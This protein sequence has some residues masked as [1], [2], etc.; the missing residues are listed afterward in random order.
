MKRTLFL[1][2][3]LLLAG[4]CPVLQNEDTPV[5]AT[6]VTSGPNRYW[7]YVPSY[8][9]TDR[10]WPLVVTLHGTH[11][12]DSDSD[13]IRSWKLLAEEKG[14]IVVAPHMRSVQGI[15]PVMRHLWYADLAKDEK[16]ILAVLD[17]VAAKYNV[18]R[19]HVILTGF[20]AGGYPLYYTGL[21]N[22]EKFEMLIPCAC[23]SDLELLKR[24]ELSPQAKK[25]PVFIFWGRDDMIIQRQSFQAV[26]FLSEN[27]CNVK[28][29]KVKGSH[30]RRPDVIYNAWKDRLPA[31]MKAQ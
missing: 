26:E 29:K 15:L 2:P 3:M 6:H 13:Q 9:T 17:E 22:P 24:I 21:R 7:V 8:H 28:F 16:T 19:E 10:T 5:S 27:Q 11:G 20:S 25:I 23:S 14:L 30:W 1:L 4:G 18:D 12:W 31:T